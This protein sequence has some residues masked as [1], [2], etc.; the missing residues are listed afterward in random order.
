M[1][2]VNTDSLGATLDALNDRFQTG[3][4]IS[5]KDRREAA[6]FIASRQG[7]PG[8]YRGMFA[9]TELDYKAGHTFYTG[10]SI[11]TGAGTAH[12][13][14]EEALRALA[15]LGVQ[16]KARDAAIAG[17]TA[18]LERILAESTSPPGFFCCGACTAA[19][20]RNLSA[21]GFPKREQLLAAG[22]KIVERLRD[23]KGR[24]KRFPFYYTVLAL[25]GLASP[26]L[27]LPGALREL[28]Y[29]APSVERALKSTSNS[30]VITQRRRALCKSVLAKV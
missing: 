19:L 18:A 6:L 13:M 21:G 7:L 9:P 15:L 8:S 24:W 20:W 25:D 27:K 26:G 29:A 14:S 28:K 4:A 10:E 23:G 5:A 2:L 11:R 1:A 16:H 17:A 3:T 30:P 22:L 12:T